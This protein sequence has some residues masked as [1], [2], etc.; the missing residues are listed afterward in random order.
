[1]QRRM[2]KS[3][4]SSR[5]TET[6]FLSFILFFSWRLGMTEELWADTAASLLD[7]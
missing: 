3:L 2:I 4:K 7:F 1:M 6:I 5:I